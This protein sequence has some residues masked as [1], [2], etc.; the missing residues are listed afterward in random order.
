MPDSRLNV[1]NDWD[2]VR[3]YLP[4]NYLAR[5]SGLDYAPH[6]ALCRIATPFAYGRI[7]EGAVRRH[8]SE[9]TGAF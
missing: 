8:A 9:L 6:A 7:A 2:T 5:S 4:A 1:T 3:S